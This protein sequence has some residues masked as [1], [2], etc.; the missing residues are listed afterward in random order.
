M[1]IRLADYRIGEVTTV[2]EQYDPKKLDIEFVDLVYSGP[3]KLD[4]TVD[5]EMDTLTF[6]G[7]LHGPMEHV[8]GRCLRRVP[9]RLDKSFEFFYEIKGRELIETLDDLREVLILDH[10]I[11]FV[12]KENCKGLCP[13]CGT[14]LNEGKCNCSLR[15]SSAPFA[16]LK[17]WKKRKEESYG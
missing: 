1:K 2:H 3:I 15:S 17:Q 7:S 13:Q 12:C 5:K 9:D 14:N 6:R 4:G 11:S 16:V 10:P 8:C